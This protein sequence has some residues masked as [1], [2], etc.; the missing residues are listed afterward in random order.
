MRNRILGGI[1]VLWGGGILVSTFMKGTPQGQG[2]YAQGQMFGIAFG[3]LL[4]LV[5]LYY[6]VKGPGKA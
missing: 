3:A 5:G 1:G 2:A 6:L 4:F